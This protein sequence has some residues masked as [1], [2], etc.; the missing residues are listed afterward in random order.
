MKEQERTK[1]EW[2]NTIL[3]IIAHIL[4]VAGIFSL[5]YLKL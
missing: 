1:I 4:I 5:I 3:L 2:K